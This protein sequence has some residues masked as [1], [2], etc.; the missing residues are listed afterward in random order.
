M[1]AASTA[2]PEPAQ[3]D[4]LG[5]EPFKHPALD[6]LAGLT[7]QR[8]HAVLDKTRTAQLA[9]KYGLVNVLRWKPKRVRDHKRNNDWDPMMLTIVSTAQQFP[10][11]RS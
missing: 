10:T 9:D 1:L 6:G 11:I 7:Q 2:T 3:V 8:K 5:R 4:E